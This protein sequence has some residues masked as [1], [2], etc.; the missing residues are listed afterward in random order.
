MSYHNPVCP[1]CVHKLHW[2]LEKSHGYL[3]SLLL[4]IGKL[5]G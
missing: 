1:G 2:F 4:I 5:L 3:I